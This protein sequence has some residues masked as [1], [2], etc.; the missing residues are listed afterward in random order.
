MLFGDGWDNGVLEFDRSSR[1]LMTFLF[2]VWGG[3]SPTSISQPR[4]SPFLCC[5][6]CEE[7]DITAAAFARVGGPQ[8]VYQFFQ[9]FLGII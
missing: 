8:I 5:M 7:N 2:F 9:V 4:G 6:L 1:N 3:F